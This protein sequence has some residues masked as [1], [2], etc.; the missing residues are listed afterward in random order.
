MGFE[1]GRRFKF[2]AASDLFPLISLIDF[3]SCFSLCFFYAAWIIL[4]IISWTQC[5]L[6]KSRHSFLAIGW[7][8]NTER[9]QWQSITNQKLVR[10]IV[11]SEVKIG[12]RTAIKLYSSS[13]QKDK[14]AYPLTNLSIVQLLNP[15]GYN[16]LQW[17]PHLSNTPLCNLKRNHQYVSRIKS[18]LTYKSLFIISNKEFHTSCSCRFISCAR[19]GILEIVRS[20]ICK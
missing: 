9:S 2:T 11:T 15:I 7:Q 13:I 6:P 10:Y 18:L 3:S 19:N 5:I 1:R 17:S 16:I 14:R 8:S 12:C 4:N 20:E